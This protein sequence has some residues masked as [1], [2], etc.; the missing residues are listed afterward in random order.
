MGD[1]VERSEPI[2]TMQAV[3][4]DLFL[5]FLLSVVI[6]VVSYTLWGLMEIAVWRGG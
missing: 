4:D 6:M 1:E 3:Y 2:P 5:I